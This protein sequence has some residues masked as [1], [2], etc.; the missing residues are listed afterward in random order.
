MHT[1]ART[2]REGILAALVEGNSLRG[3]ARMAD[4][5]YNTVLKFA[6]DMGH[7]CDAY[8]DRTFHHLICKS[9]QLDE[10]WSFIHHRR[11]TGEDA[12]AGRGEC[13]TFVAIDADTKLVPSWAT[14]PRSMRTALQFVGDLHSRL[15]NRPQITTD[16]FT[17]YKFAVNHHFGPAVDYAMLVKIYPDG[18]TDPETLQLVTTPGF[19]PVAVSGNPDPRRMSTNIV[20]RQNLTMRTC[21]RRFMR[22]TNGHSKKIENHAAAIALHFFAYNFIRIHSTIRTTPAMAAGVTDRLW[23]YGDLLDMYDADYSKHRNSSNRRTD[24]IRD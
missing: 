5:A 21:M 11:P 14:G 2:K 10:I 12:T 15:V 8:Q 7:A 9:V 20:E 24:G 16:G 22:K 23:S 4:V 1:L 19:N 13:W 3:T 6:A 17:A 18:R